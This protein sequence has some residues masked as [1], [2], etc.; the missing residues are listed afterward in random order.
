MIH[1]LFDEEYE[2]PDTSGVNQYVPDDFPRAGISTII[3]VSYR[4]FDLPNIGYPRF[5]NSDVF[6]VNLGFYIYI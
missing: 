2:D 4:F 1:N 5:Q 3:G 6:L